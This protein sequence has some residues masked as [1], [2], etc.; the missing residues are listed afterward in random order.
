MTQC[1]EC[2]A[3]LPDD[4]RTCMQCGTNVELSAR[5][6][7]TQGTLQFVQPAIAGGL[8]LGILSS[9]PYIN[10][11]NL[12]FGM[13]M[14]AGGALTAHLLGKQRPSGI[15][16]GD[17]AFGG[18]LSGFVGA[19]VATILLIPSKMIFVA[20]FQAQHVEA[21]RTFVQSPELA[22]PMRD[23]ILRALSPEVSLATEVFWFFVLGM[24]FSLFAMFGGILM[25]GIMNRRRRK[26]NIAQP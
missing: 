25:V 20:D 19:I 7:G 17:G 1:R 21:E 3:K 11:G 26:R 9:L 4:A 2:G 6:H 8:L 10:A 12:F 5:S 15:G 24:F 18:V 16:Y 13:W 14:L 22:G 23:L